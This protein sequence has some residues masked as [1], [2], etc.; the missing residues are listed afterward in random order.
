MSFR[1]FDTCT[2]N[3]PWFEK[4]STSAKLLFVYLFTNNACNQAGLY[5]ITAKRIKFE[6]DIDIDKYTTELQEKVFWSPQDNVV[7]VKNFFK[8]QCQNDKFA[9]A[10]LSSVKNLPA[11]YQEM[12]VQRYGS[13]LNRY[14]IDT[15]SIPT[16]SA[17]A[18][19]SVSD[20][21]TSVYTDTTVEVDGAE[22]KPKTQG[23][24]KLKPDAKHPYADFVSLTN[25]EHSSLVAKYGEPGTQRM[26]E[27]LNNFKG[28][29][30][31]KY[32]SDYRAILNW[33]VERYE[34]EQAKNT[35]KKE[36]KRHP[37]DF[38]KVYL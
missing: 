32:K 26:I 23:T 12:F 19:V 38:Y 30:D 13:L 34:K 3:D 7:W 11:K 14:G 1:K 24:P 2:W 29:N 22:T 27:I 31:T 4:L 18:S 35:V 16:I 10:A 6:C 8:H 21:I 5:Q 25:D 36:E 20:L 15:V 28:Q 17:S 9:K 37:T 33:V